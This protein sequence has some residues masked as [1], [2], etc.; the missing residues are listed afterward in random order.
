MENESIVGVRYQDSPEKD[1]WDHQA[2]F[3]V[4]QNTDEPAWKKLVDEDSDF[5]DKTKQA[6]SVCAQS[7]PF[8]GPT[9]QGE[10]YYSSGAYLAF[11]DTGLFCDTPLKVEDFFHT[12]IDSPDYSCPVSEMPFEYD[13]WNP[14]WYSHL[15]RSWYKLQE[16]KP[17]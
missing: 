7:I 5:N 15:C 12:P 16:N 14:K 11:K 10:Q 9:L 8:L 2:W 4:P 3:V 1:I 6:R 13:D 17:N